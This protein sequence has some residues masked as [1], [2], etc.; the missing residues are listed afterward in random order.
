MSVNEKL[1]QEC[2]D[3][4]GFE[5]VEQQPDGL[6]CEGCMAVH[7]RPTK[8]YSNGDRGLGHCLCKFQVVRLFNPSDP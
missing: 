6:Y 1:F 3:G 7:R 8:M 5:E 4:Y 2:R